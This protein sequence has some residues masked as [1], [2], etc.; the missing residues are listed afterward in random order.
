M[1]LSDV[2][3]MFGSVFCGLA[4][5]AVL[6]FGLVGCNVQQPTPVVVPDDCSESIIYNYAA[7]TGMT[8]S[9]VGA[10]FKVASTLA[11][12]QEPGFKTDFLVLLTKMEVI[13]Q[14]EDMK[15]SDLARYVLAETK[16]INTRWGKAALVLS[17]VLAEFDREV[18]LNSCD[19][20]LILKH[21]QEQKA[22]AEMI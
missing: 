4:A 18:P 21:I 6:M 17:V 11:L 14:T 15:A 20:R 19:R 5:I 16:V 22:L 3:S 1:K 9:Q 12:T 10:I 8:P 13:L 2:I 7:K